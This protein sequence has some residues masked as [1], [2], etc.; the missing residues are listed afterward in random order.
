MLGYDMNIIERGIRGIFARE[1]MTRQRKAK[2]PIFC[3]IVDSDKQTEKYNA[4]ST[5]PQLQ[6][7]TDERVL[8]GFSEYSYEITN[9]VYM[10]GIKVPRTLFEFDQT[11]QL[12]TLVQSLGSRVANFPDALTFTLL[13][14]SLSALGYD[15]CPFCDD[16]TGAAGH[17]LGDGNKQYNLLAGNMDN[18]SLAGATKALRDNM[19]AAFQQDLRMAKAMLLELNDDRGEPWHDDAEPESL[20]ILCH[21]R[22]EFFVRTALEGS[23][24]NDTSN[25]TVKSVGRIL[26][27]N[28]EAPFKVNTTLMYGTW[29]LFKIDTPIKPLIF[30]RFGP[31]TDFPD[32]IP[33]ADQAPLQ[34]LNSVEVQTIMRTGSDIS[35]TTFFDDDF[36]FGA[37]VLY[38]AGFGMWQN[39][40]RVNGKATA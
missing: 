34:A 21:P 2:Y 32:T 4:I 40:I 31:K 17:D 30:Q 6:E 16:A 13:G 3:S 27:T 19:I 35:E 8:A 24:I 7:T 29:Y 15:G 39:C 38:S 5:L 36:L 22:A 9:K 20:V 12:R 23:I 37:R 11:G 14:T 1:F 10:T 18:A 25:I 26:T 28:R 33:E